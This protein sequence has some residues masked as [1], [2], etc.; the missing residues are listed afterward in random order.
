M[1]RA[2]RDT[3]DFRELLLRQSFFLSERSDIGCKIILHDFISS[4]VSIA[5]TVFIV[6]ENAKEGNTLPIQLE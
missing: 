6:E 2:D 4:T 1:D 3:E 5:S